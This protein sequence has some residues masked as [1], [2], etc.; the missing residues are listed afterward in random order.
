MTVIDGI[1]CGIYLLF[2]V[3]LGFFSKT[4]VHSMV[5]FLVAGRNISPFLGV[6]SL[7]GTELGLITVMY[8]AQ[9]GFATG[10]SALHMAI[11]AG[12][13]TFLV[14]KSGFVIVP[15]RRLKVLTIPEFY[16]LTFDR[17]TRV[18]GAIIL[19]LAGIL[20]MG[21]F[22]K[23]SAI[24][25]SVIFG[26]SITGWPLIISMSILLV[27]VLFYTLMGG[28]VSVIITDFIQF[29]LLSIGLT[30]FVV[31]LYL[32]I[33]WENL[34]SGWQAFHGLA[35]FNP[36]TKESGFGLSYVIWMI[37]TARL[38]SI[39]IWPTALTRA[40]VMP[41]DESVK[42]QYMLASIPMMARFV[43]PM[44]IGAMAFIVL[45][46][47]DSLTALPRVALEVLPVGILGLLVAGLLAA[48]MSTFDG[49]LLCWSSVI[50]RDIIM[51]L[52]K[53]SWSDKKQ[54]K[55]IRITV[56]I[57]GLFMLY[58]GLFYQGSEDI[59]DYLAI[60]GAIYFTG[61][62]PLMVGGLYWKKA[63]STG[64][65][66]SLISGLIA[67]IGLEPIHNYL[68]ISLDASEIGIITVLISGICFIIG[69]IIW[70]KEKMA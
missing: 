19:V 15:L 43:L 4:K 35:G 48:M 70:P 66:A 41:D 53:T 6:A 16:E 57:C 59:W 14:G 12:V 3:W 40:L 10:L 42:K 38:V 2:I 46:G 61:A 62:I 27:L 23:V 26:W 5:D 11:I 51:P 50:I 58:W 24:F 13:I 44:M 34:I 39:A 7:G 9:K 33:G 29:I 54:M 32:G 49:Y 65:K 64:A 63:S 68:N 67:L 20:N 37:I 36:F 21:L 22:L 31:I 17:S 47:G 25:I 55:A 8:N 28:M 18:L 56:I 45:G 30:V 1:I 69:S 60:T 52:S